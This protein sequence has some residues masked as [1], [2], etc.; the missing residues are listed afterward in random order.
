MWFIGAFELGSFVMQ[1]I[2]RGSVLC[3]IPCIGQTGRSIE[4]SVK[5]YHQHMLSPTVLKQLEQDVVAEKRRR[6]AKTS[7]KAKVLGERP[8]GQPS[9]R[10]PH[11][12][13]QETSVSH[14]A[15]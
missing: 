1:Y 7:A 13:G 12:T 8:T 14:K 11:S 5:K 10:Q 6:E 4:T 9:G 15:P 2:S 3:C